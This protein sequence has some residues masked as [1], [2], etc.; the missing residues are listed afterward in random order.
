MTSDNEAL[1]AGAPARLTIDLTAIQDNVT[2]LKELAGAAQVLAVVK[3]DAYGHGLVPSAQ[4]AVRGGATWLGVAQLAE[5]IKL[6]DA[7][8][9][10]PVISW[11]H[12][13]GLDFDAAVER[14]I[15]VGVPAIW[16]L[17]AVAAAARRVGT[18][19]RLHLKVDTGLARNGAY[20]TDWTDLV[21][22]AGPLVAEGVVDVVGV[23]TH[24][25]CADSPEHP[26]VQAQQDK[27]ADAVTDVERA[28]FDIEVRHM[29]NSAAT[30]TRPSAAW[31][32]VRPGLAV[33]GLSP[34]PQLGDPA[35]FGLRP[36][37]TASANITVVK[38]I[39]AGQGVSY[40]Y[41]YVPD[42][43][44]TVVDVPAGYADGVPRSASNVGPVQVAGARH[45]IAGRVCMDQFVVDVGD[46]EV[47]A[48][49]PVLLFGPGT[50]GEP[51]A[52][53]WADA[54]DTISYEIV[55]RMSSR[56]PRIYLGGH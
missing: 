44:T 49:D 41:T 42:R 5:A 16:E 23:F 15:D 27:F 26:S 25:A 34:V 3:G 53:D 4:A 43:E 7:G 9:E 38:R 46:D 20:G 51:T 30:L 10:T 40:G 48:G 22:A 55:T 2:R 54:T 6:R 45:T 12:A 17:E 29:S 13:P 11:L 36:A 37:M 24:F 39:P 28:G 50:D 47:R 8:I 21:A 52:Q 31:D 14:R 33:Y 19:A 32:M 56:L 18:T 1:P 35:S